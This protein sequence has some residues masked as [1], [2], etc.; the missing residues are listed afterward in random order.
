M[1]VVSEAIREARQAIGLEPEA[2]AEAAGIDLGT[3]GA[4]ESGAREVPGDV[5]WRLSDALGIPL[6]ELDSPAALRRHVDV[7]A[8]RF[9]AGQQAV[10]DRVRL[11]VARAASAARDYVG[12]E[13]LA[14]RPRR[15]QMLVEQWPGKPPL[16][17]HETWKSGRGLAEDLR[18]RLELRGPVGSML[19]LVEK[20]LGAL[21]VWQK[22]P[23]DFAGYA[24]CDEIHGP[25]IVLNVNGRNQNELVRRFTLAHEAGHVLF[26]RHDLAA[27]SRF[28]SYDDFYGYH[29]DDGKD[30]HEIRA[31]AFAIH[32]LA[33][34]LLLKEAWAAAG[35]DVRSVMTEFGIS[36]EAARHHLDNYRLF[37]LTERLD[38]VPTS[39][40]DEWKMAE[41]SE[42]WYPAFDDIPIE[43]RHA[44]ARLAFELWT[45]GKLT[46]GR[47]REVLRV[48]LA[49]QQLV[50]L[51]TLYLG[52]IAA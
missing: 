14:E 26:D 42:L 19:E 37:P 46:T 43:R 48:N 4:Y 27:L 18:E 20:R 41:S 12:L 28:D 21:V 23:V 34:E 3:L 2:L 51:A 50:E 10:P 9:R 36:F 32:L 8:V 40:T 11:A 44:V 35:T 1:T 6:E 5:L 13:D 39:A 31:N 45:T 38:R 7:M 47:L 25:A 17:R 15:Y 33:P 24:F 29:D 16:S 30:P 22:L 52:T 49:H